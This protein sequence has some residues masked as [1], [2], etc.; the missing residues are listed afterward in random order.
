M[1]HFSQSNPIVEFPVRYPQ[2]GTTHQAIVSAVWRWEAPP[3]LRSV[4]CHKSWECPACQKCLS[5]MASAFSH[6]QEPEDF[7]QPLDPRL[8]PGWQE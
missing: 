2:D 1:K 3:L 6:D 5:V 4:E 7:F 8:L